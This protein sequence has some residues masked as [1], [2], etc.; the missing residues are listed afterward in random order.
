MNNE[1]TEILLCG[2]NARLKSVHPNSLKI[3][4]NIIDF[5]PKVKNLGMCLENNLS[6][7]HAVSHLRKSCYLE[8]RKIANI[9][10]YLSDS[11]TQKLVISKLDYYNSLFH[12]MNLENIHKL[13]LIQN[14]AARLVKKHQNDPVLNYY[15]KRS[16]L[17]AS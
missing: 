1:K 8:L 3:G 17:A 5:S 14:H 2:T 15:L 6:M 11:A 10:S 13:Q 9:P 4:N 7:D 12:N 16:S